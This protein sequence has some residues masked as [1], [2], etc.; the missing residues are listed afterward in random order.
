MMIITSCESC[1]PIQSEA[2]VCETQDDF[3]CSY[4]QKAAEDKLTSSLLSIETTTLSTEENC[5]EISLENGKFKHSTEDKFSSYDS[6]EN[7]E[8]T[9]KLSNTYVVSDVGAP[10]KNS[11]QTYQENEQI[12]SEQPK[13]L[14][15]EEGNTSSAY[16]VFN[17][18]E[19]VNKLDIKPGEYVRTM[20]D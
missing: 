10:L 12:P 13:L 18:A 6:Q 20:K 19:L 16:A 7:S 4:Q 11:S 17:N 9:P 14:R 8:Q 1:K 15:H 2:D 5:S 3:M